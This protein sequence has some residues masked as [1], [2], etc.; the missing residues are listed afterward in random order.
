MQNIKF[1]VHLETLNGAEYKSADLTAKIFFFI[2]EILMC[3]EY[4]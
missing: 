2:R 3:L 4:K 1:C